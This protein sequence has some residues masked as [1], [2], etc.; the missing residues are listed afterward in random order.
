MTDC[1]PVLHFRIGLLEENCR[2]QH[3]HLFLFLKSFGRNNETARSLK[4]EIG[5]KEGNRIGFKA[6]NHFFTARSN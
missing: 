2:A 6:R 3:K 1:R 5:K 4:E